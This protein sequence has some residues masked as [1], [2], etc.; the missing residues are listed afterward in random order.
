MNGFVI[1]YVITIAIAIYDSW[2]LG[3]IKAQLDIIEKNITD[4][5][6]KND[7]LF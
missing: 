6:N 5:E 4:E 7:K 3:I 2:S 1:L